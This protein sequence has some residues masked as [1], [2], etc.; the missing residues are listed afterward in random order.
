MTPHKCQVMHSPERGFYGDCLRAC[1]AS[2]LDMEP[3]TVPHF[4]QDG[5]DS[6]EGEKRI[7]AFLRTLNLGTFCAYFPGSV[8][9]QDLLDH[10]AHDSSPDVCQ[11]LFCSVNGGNHAV[12]IQNGR[13]IHDPALYVVRN[14][15]PV[16]FGVWVVM[17]LVKL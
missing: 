17:V 8:P 2:V 16:D 9:L 6:I 4:Y 14:Y 12:V 1:I 13:V 3:A 10:M 15:S 11:I 5:C 7:V